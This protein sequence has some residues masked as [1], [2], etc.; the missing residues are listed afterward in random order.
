MFWIVNCF[1]GRRKLS[2]DLL[3]LDL[4]FYKNMTSYLI[5]YLFLCLLS[6]L[7][8]PSTPHIDFSSSTVNTVMVLRSQPASAWHTAGFQLAKPYK[9]ILSYCRRQWPTRPIPQYT[10]EVGCSVGCVGVTTLF[11]HLLMLKLTLLAEFSSALSFPA[12][13]L[14]ADFAVVMYFLVLLTFNRTF[15][16][17]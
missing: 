13:R 9:A 5:Q 16:F 11:K 8:T 2:L 3:Q 10:D 14:T 12:F 15:H 7:H 17:T 1:E 4:L 6:V